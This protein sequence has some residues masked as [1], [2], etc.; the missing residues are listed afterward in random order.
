[1]RIG[2]AIALSISLL[3]AKGAIADHHHPHA[4]AN[5]ARSQFSA[6][7]SLLAAQ[8]D[9]MTYGGDYEGVIPAI[10]WSSGRYAAMASMAAYRLEENGRTLAGIGDLM[11]GGSAMLTEHVGVMLMA[12]VPTGEKFLG[13]GHVMAMP[14]VFA[15]YHTHP[16][17][18]GASLGADRALN[19]SAEHAGHGAWPLVEPMNMSEIA[20]SASSDLMVTDT[21]TAG[22]RLSG[23]VPVGEPGVN[24]VIGGVRV[25]WAQGKL[26][27]G[28]EL[29][30]GII[31]DPFVV[32]GVLE[33]SV[34]F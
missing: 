29:Q 13:M 31:G 27:T 30:A 3:G 26:T 23:G 18:L 5:E 17:M 21:I 16:L 4:D 15:R 2:P 19:G 20:W 28:A 1:M 7:L 25:G 8:Y 11:F 24:R 22:A 32:R 12:M 34:A 9:T 33:T 10:G 14:S 6:Q